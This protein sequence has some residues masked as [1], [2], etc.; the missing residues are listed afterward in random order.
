MVAWLVVEGRRLEVG[1][2][3]SCLSLVDLAGKM[4]YNMLVLAPMDGIVAQC[5]PYLYSSSGKSKVPPRNL[6]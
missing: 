3:E 6:I 4:L 2:I 1:P 5:P